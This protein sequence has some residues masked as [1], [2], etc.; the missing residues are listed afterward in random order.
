M[1][2]LYRLCPGVS[3]A[4]AVEIAGY[5][6]LAMTTRNSDKYSADSRKIIKFMSTQRNGQGGFVST[7]VKC[8]SMIGGLE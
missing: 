3:S 2:I 5:A 1:L 4:V 6:V 7:Q 8:L